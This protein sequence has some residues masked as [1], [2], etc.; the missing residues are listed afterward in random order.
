MTKIKMGSLI[1]LFFGLILGGIWGFVLTNGRATRANQQPISHVDAL[2]MEIDNTAKQEFDKG[3]VKQD[4]FGNPIF[5][6]ESKL[7]ID[8]LNNQILE[9]NRAEKIRSTEEV[10]A[11]KNNIRT[12]TGKHDIEINFDN[13]VNNPYTKIKKHDVEYYRDSKDTM[14]MVDPATNKVVAFTYNDHFITAPDKKLSKNKLREIARAYLTKHAEGFDLIEKT[15]ILE[16]GLKGDMYV[17]RYN[18]PKSVEGEDMVPFVQ[19]KL[20]VGGELIGFSD[21]RSLYR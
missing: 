14:Y 9:A 12:I 11:V 1:V 16:E 15:Y 5:C 13:R 10:A 20:S 8:N 19:V 6:G 21:I 17:L 2:R 7:K 18:A 3:C 4:S